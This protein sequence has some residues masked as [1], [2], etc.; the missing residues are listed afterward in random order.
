MP[1]LR[2]AFSVSV[3]ADFD[4]PPR[5]LRLTLPWPLANELLSFHPANRLCADDPIASAVTTF[6]DAFLSSIGIPD[7]KTYPNLGNFRTLYAPFQTAVLGGIAPGIVACIEVIVGFV[8]GVLTILTTLDP[9]A[10][11]APP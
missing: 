6:V 9:G 3:A 10:V 2:H 8:G 7:G 11:A 4:H 1:V 5:A